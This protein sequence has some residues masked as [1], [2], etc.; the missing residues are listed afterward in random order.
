[1][2]NL[3]SIVLGMFLVGCA[4][5][6]TQATLPVNKV[7]AR[8][9]YYN[10]HEDKWGARVACGNG[11]ACEGI[12]C[13]AHPIFDFG[14]KVIIPQLKGVVGAGE[15]IVQDRGTA[16]T[17]KKA[18]GGKEFVFDVFVN[19]SRKATVAFASKLPAYMDVILSKPI[20]LFSNNGSVSHKH[21]TAN[22]KNRK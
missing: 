5:I 7:R 19:K 22:R 18:S 4:N 20:E 13:A 17:N 21:M 9:T 6:E 1:M 15:F 2:R 12:T 11:R 3:L 16:V 8:V 10:A 14:T